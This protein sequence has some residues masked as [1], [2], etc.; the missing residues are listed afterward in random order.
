[1]T[2][3]SPY[4][5]HSASVV[6]TAEHHDP[7]VLNPS[8]MADS[9][10][11]PADWKVTES[12]NTLLESKI[13]YEKILWAINPSKLEVV[14]VCE[15][16]FKDK[17][18]IYGMVDDYLSK[19]TYIPYRNFG[20]NY[21]VFMKHDHP[22]LWLVQQFLRSDLWTE[23]ESNVLFIQPN[24]YLDIGDGIQCKLLLNAGNITPPQGKP[25][26]I[27]VADINIDHPASSMDEM[28]AAISR[29]PERQEFVISLLD[30]LLRRDV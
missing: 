17:Y 19:F 26:R 18:L 21:R 13:Q 22:E 20:L 24:L 23:E 27:V 6:I 5:L 7:M 14:E 30:K 11:V 2:P 12:S 15:S 9:K 10:I 28:R 3:S 8:I 1:M 4:L 16:P 25:E 29:W